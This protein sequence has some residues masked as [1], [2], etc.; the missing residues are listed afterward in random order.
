MSIKRLKKELEEITNDPPTNCS[1]GIIDD[2]I[3]TWD[4]T[5]IGPEKTPY[6]N[7]VFK[8]TIVF[9][10]TYPFKPPKVVINNLYN[11]R[12][13]LRT[14]PLFKSYKN[15]LKFDGCL[16]CQ[17]ILCNW[18]VIFNFNTIINEVKTNFILI[19]KL[20][21]LIF[22]KNIMI[23]NLGFEIPILYQFI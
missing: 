15:Y 8:L 13:L 23:K 2:D 12:D 10:E 9:P 11:Y 18:F 5:I 21:N 7:G 19:N 14:S 20:K 1:A 16:C 22:A 17:S 6:E 4:A 3:N